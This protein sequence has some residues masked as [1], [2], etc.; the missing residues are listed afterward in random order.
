M[1][2]VIMCYLYNLFSL[3]LTLFFN[4]VLFVFVIEKRRKKRNW[5]MV[6]KKE[7]EKEREIEKN[8]SDEVMNG[9]WWCWY[10]ISWRKDDLNN[11]SKMIGLVILNG[12]NWLITIS[13]VIDVIRMIFDVI[14][15]D[16]NVYLFHHVFLNHISLDHQSMT[17][18]EK[19]NKTRETK[20]I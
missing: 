19:W 12:G 13:H 1:L 7:K 3:F 17:M 2:F 8:E 16:L 15:D 11:E 14:W 20:R 4:F 10:Q 9:I 5:E 6:L 18:D